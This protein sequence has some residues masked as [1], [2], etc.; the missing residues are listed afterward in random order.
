MKK[1]VARC[2]FSLFFCFYAT[3]T[4]SQLYNFRTFTVEDGLSQSKIKALY[5]DKSGNLWIGTLGGGL[6]KYSSKKYINLTTINGLTDNNVTSIA[7]DNYGNC[8]IGT[9][10]GLS[11]YNGRTFKPYTTKN[12][13]PNNQVNAVCVDQFGNIWVGTDRGLCI[14]S[15]TDSTRMHYKYANYDQKDGLS[16]EKINSIFMDKKN[17]IWIATDDGVCKVENNKPNH[18]FN[19][20]VITEKDGLASNEVTSITQDPN[21][22]IW[23]ATRHGVSKLINKQGEKPHFLNYTSKN[24]LIQDNI[25]YVTADQRG[26]IWFCT[27]IGVTRVLFENNTSN[28]Q[29]VNYNSNAGLPEG[30]I[31]TALEDREGN[32]WLGT[33]SGLTRYGGD[34]FISF[35][36]DHNLLSNGIRSITGDI[37]GNIVIGTDK[38]ACVIVPAADQGQKVVNFA[39]QCHLPVGP[40]QALCLDRENN[41]W[42][43][44]NS[45]V[46]KLAVKSKT[47]PVSYNCETITNKECF[48][49]LVSNIIEDSRG[50]IWFGTAEGLVR[51]DGQSYKKFTKTDGLTD[52]NITCLLEDR[53]GKIWVGTDQGLS[54]FDGSRFEKYGS[55][56]GL[57]LQVTSIA[58]DESGNL[59]LGS[60]SGA[61]LTRF[62]GQNYTNISEA[63]GLISNTI[64]LLELDNTG[65]LW[66]GT[67]KGL[68]LID[69][70]HYNKTDSIRIRHYGKSEGFAGIQ[71]TQNAVYK[72]FTG[73]IWFGTVKGVV[74]Y[75]PKEDIENAMP[76]VTQFTGL[77]LFN[78]DDVSWNKYSDS[79]DPDNGM[80]L[81]LVLP[82]NQNSLTINFLGV[83]LTNPD[84]VR[85]KY[86]LEG[87]SDEWIETTELNAPLQNLS[88]GQYTFYLKACNND[89]V[90]NP[91]PLQFKFTINP[92]FW[93]TPLFYLASLVLL[94]VGVWLYVRRRTQQLHRSKK[95]LE[96]KIIERTKELQEKNVELEK[97]S[98]VARETVN[99]IAIA[100]PT[101]EIEWVNE[102]YTRMTGYTLLDLHQ[103]E[104]NTI[105]QTK[106]NAELKNIVM[107][108]LENKQS[109]VFESLNTTK[110]GKKIWIHTTLT[111]VI[112]ES[113][114]VK[115]MV[116]IDTDIT[117]TKQ[118]EE[119][120][121]RKNKDMM[122]SINY[123]KL[124]Q[125][126]ILPPK[127]EILRVFPESFLFFRPREVVSGDFYWFTVV[128][129]IAY[130]A[131]ADSTGHGV[132]G[133]FMSLIGSS[134]L[135]ETVIQK[136][137]LDTDQILNELD[138]EIRIVLKHGKEGIETKDG[139]D[140]A[141]IA[142]NLNT[143]V[144]HYSGAMRPMYIINKNPNFDPAA[145]P[146][147]YELKVIPP[148]KR[149]IGGDQM[150][151]VPTF[152]KHEI[153][154][155]Q[156]DAIYLFTDGYADQFGGPRG[157][158][159][160]NAR[161]KESFLSLQVLSMNLQGKLLE[162]DL[163]KWMGK[164]EQVD[165][166][167]VLGIKF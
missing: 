123:A 47:N 52:N 150:G 138:H 7:G 125:D 70:N 89:G 6:S 146:N 79:I 9:N 118:A 83:S 39:D 158:K 106:N 110:D 95:E 143:K 97:L 46:Y 73:N 33:E 8:W 145:S 101:G 64:Y 43:G 111:P 130:V 167:L 29:L 76:P 140:V 98:I 60:Y 96:Q 141:L 18:H 27:D 5:Q 37:N 162:Q 65:A 154:L 105:F 108:C 151:R 126:A 117:E 124:I 26:N 67:N 34:R 137:I 20:T 53:K 99:A 100:S 23:F 38:G 149:S 120:I 55:F 112:D 3:N 63:D 62:D 13:L 57:K 82:Y 19:F 12:G 35:T 104:G 90:W 1:T 122:D 16:N 131:V 109:S 94:V 30:H 28:L 80:P 114:H 164:L 81:H 85:Y 22:Y 147:E 45:V 86:K 165:D 61:G 77:K 50:S 93:K 155:Q 144:M 14:L 148:D 87:N 15:A 88:Y 163:K 78:K 139:M 17:T 113:G 128:G 156:G 116:F 119:I 25:N 59:W 103:G 11:R 134:L 72:D 48:N 56:S 135:N 21:S 161:F 42:L 152:S 115:K 31:N 51:F 91:I 166:I 40:I 4:F 68:D 44:G 10:K 157:K 159:I 49:G 24:G 75:S 129:E 84:K 121:R 36:K 92:P 136:G 107:T 153:Q 74:K 142:I 54:S 2:L 160:T 58:E 32:V 66:I 133:A 127:D 132:P 71:C 69:V 41:I 102:S